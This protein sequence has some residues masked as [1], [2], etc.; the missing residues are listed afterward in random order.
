MPLSPTKAL[1]H[2]I[3][4][5]LLAASFERARAEPCCLMDGSCIDIARDDCI[6]GH[7]YLSGATDCSEAT[8]QPRGACW[9]LVDDYI[10]CL[11]TTAPCRFRGAYAGDGTR[12]DG[13]FPAI[14][15]GACCQPD[16]T[17]AVRNEINCAADGSYFHGPG[18]T[19]DGIDCAVQGACCTA[20]GC[21]IA[22]T[23]ATIFDCRNGGRVFRPDVQTCDGDT[24]AD[25]MEENGGCCLLTGECLIGAARGDCVI[26]GGAFDPANADC[27]SPCTALIGLCYFDDGTCEP[28]EFL[29]CVDVRGGIFRDNSSFDSNRCDDYPPEEIGYCCSNSNPRLERRMDSYAA[30]RIGGGL[31]AFV[32]NMDECTEDRRA[33]LDACPIG[34]PVPPVDDNQNE[35]ENSVVD[36]PAGDPPPSCPLSPLPLAVVPVL[37]LLRGRAGTGPRLTA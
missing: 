20:N 33:S 15:E 2:L 16:D 11:E 36:P 5:A 12:C 13:G 26:L 34:S 9:I 21:G 37:A 10:T 1:Q 28:R 18:T 32:R 23:M 27:A 24:C 6:D 7:G 19:C 4:L 29:D 14:P 30:R 31:A 35:N 17:C 22:C 25:F 8:C 3:T